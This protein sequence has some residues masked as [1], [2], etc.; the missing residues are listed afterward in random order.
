MTHNYK[1]HYMKYSFYLFL[2][3]CSFI[4][5]V[6]AQENQCGT[7]EA[8]KNTL[9]ADI[10]IEFRLAQIDP[11]GNCTNGIDR[12]YSSLTHAGSD[13]SKLNQWPRDKY[14]NVWTVSTIGMSGVAGYAYFPSAT[15]SYLYIYDGII[16]LS[17]FISS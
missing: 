10:R 16:I 7:T 8:T 3:I 17:N 6:F 9:A 5:P 14:L 13:Q 11:N 12:I 4:Q 1:R 2:L 15:N